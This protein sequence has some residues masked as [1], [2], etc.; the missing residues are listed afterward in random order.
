MKPELSPLEYSKVVNQHD[1]KPIVVLDDE[2]KLNND[3]VEDYGDVI[4]A[5]N[6]VLL[7]E[8]AQTEKSGQEFALAVGCSL[9]V[10]AM[11]DACYE[12][13]D[14]EHAKRI[15][16]LD[17]RFGATRTA[18]AAHLEKIFKTLD[19]GKQRHASLMQILTTTLKNKDLQQ[20][21]PKVAGIRAELSEE[22]REIES[23]RESL[24]KTI[25]VW[26]DASS[27]QIVNQLPS[28]LQRRIREVLQRENETLDSAGICRGSTSSCSEVVSY[29]LN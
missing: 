21:V 14:A 4:S 7:Q 22:L 17:R 19:D 23:T 25:R 16:A 29:S 10:M 5:M 15:Q 18:R 1:K 2:V 6:Q 27:S 13:E 11:I 9:Q 12:D 8:K 26:F 20:N 28:D 24:L 3:K